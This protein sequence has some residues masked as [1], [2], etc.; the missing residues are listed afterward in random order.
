[1]KCEACECEF[2]V[3]NKIE[4]V[5][6]SNLFR[7]T[8]VLSVEGRMDNNKPIYRMDYESE[9]IEEGEI[10]DCWYVCAFCGNIIPESRVEA[11]VL[12]YGGSDEV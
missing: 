9:T 8:P 5:S 12:A 3:N 6:L 7:Y 11:I 1:M 4:L 2:G 10:T